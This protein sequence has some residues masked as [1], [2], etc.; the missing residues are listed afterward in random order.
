MKA[1]LKSVLLVGAGALA[2]GLGSG[3][4]TDAQY[5]DPTNSKT[6]VTTLGSINVQ[7]W[8]TAADQMIQS[9]LTS[10][11]IANVPKQP[12]VMAIDRIVNKTD[13]ANLDTESLTKKIRVALN[14]SGKV[15]TTTT[16]GRNA[17]SGMAADVLAKQDFMG[18]DRPVD[19]SPDFTLTGKIIKNQARA[20]GTT[21][22]TFVFQLSLTDT[23]SGLAVWEEEKSIQKTADRNV[24]GW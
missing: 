15:L 1:S 13:D 16:Y 12:A 11:A 18:G 23:R 10:P 4:A 5:T 20:G 19:R 6:Q 9:L 3:C 21:Q 14:K 24:L 17:E 7:D 22:V 8:D 2:L